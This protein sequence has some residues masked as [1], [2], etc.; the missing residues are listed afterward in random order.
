MSLFFRKRNLHTALV[1]DIVKY[2]IIYPADI[3]V[4]DLANYQ[5]VLHGYHLFR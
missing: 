3:T 4:R 2:S 5:G 1:N